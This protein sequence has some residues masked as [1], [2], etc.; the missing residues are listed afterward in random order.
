MRINEYVIINELKRILLHWLFLLKAR[1]SVICRY[2]PGYN[3]IL[4]NSVNNDML[5]YARQY[6]RLFSR[7]LTKIHL[8]TQNL[9]QF[10]KIYI[11]TSSVQI[12][13]LVNKSGRFC[14]LDLSGKP[15]PPTN[16]TSF[17]LERSLGLGFDSIHFQL[18]KL[19]PGLP[20]P[21]FSPSDKSW[22]PKTHWNVLK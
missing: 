3:N 12:S 9:G 2:T 13:V 15:F 11:A 8:L 7:K 17:S 14:E 22:C 6:G 4:L 5:L 1:F 16:S 20:T 18:P 19:Q 10:Y 21:V